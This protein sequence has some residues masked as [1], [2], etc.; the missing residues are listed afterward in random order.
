MKE[1]KQHSA[2][3]KDRSNVLVHGLSGEF[4]GCIVYIGQIYW[5]MACQVNLMAVLCM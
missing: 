4:N 2:W 5:F 1:K 3:V